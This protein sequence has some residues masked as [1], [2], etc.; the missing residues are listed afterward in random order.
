MLV[1]LGCQQRDFDEFW[2]LLDVLGA[3]ARVLACAWRE[4]VVVVVVVA[5]N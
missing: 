3:W 2:I 1:V 5:R 4:A